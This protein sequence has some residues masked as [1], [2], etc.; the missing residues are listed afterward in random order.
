M[1]KI[2]MKM[3]DLVWKILLFILLLNKSVLG[4]YENTWNSYFEQPCCGSTSN[5]QHHLRHHKGNLINLVNYI[6]REKF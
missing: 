4:D 6:A 3:T 1:E 5:Q 2:G